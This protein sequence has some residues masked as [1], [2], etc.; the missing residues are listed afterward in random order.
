MIYMPTSRTVTLD[1]T[2]LSTSAVAF[3]YDPSNGTYITISGSPFANAGTR[4]FT[5]PG[6]NS[7]GDGDWVLIVQAGS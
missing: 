1:M 6:N 3:W 5:P 2:K 7:G 4:Q